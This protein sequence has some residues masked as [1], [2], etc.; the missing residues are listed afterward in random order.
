MNARPYNLKEKAPYTIL[1][2][3]LHDVMPLQT[4]ITLYL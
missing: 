2:E 3:I 4:T 1:D